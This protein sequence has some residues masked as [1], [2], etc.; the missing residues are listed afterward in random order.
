MNV[1]EITLDGIDNLPD[2]K[3]SPAQIARLASMAI[4]KAADRARTRGAASIRQQVAFPANYLRGDESRLAVRKPRATADNLEAIITGRHRATS[5]AR[6]SNT[7]S[8][9]RGR[10]QGGLNIQVKPGEAKFVKGAFLVKLR[11]GATKTDTK[12]NLGVAIRLKNGQRPRNTRAAVQLDHNV[13]LLYGPSVDQVWRSVREDIS[14][15]ITEYLVGEFERLL[16]V[17]GL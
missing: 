9:A 10:K 4:N 5:L 12:F 16:G 7:T 13:W 2:L 11:A 3:K 1:F 8:Q 15:E 6:F 17:E 14:P